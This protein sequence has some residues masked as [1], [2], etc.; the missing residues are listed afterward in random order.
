MTAA[1]AAV[2]CPA[3]ASVTRATAT[4]GDTIELP[5]PEA[6]KVQEDKLILR[7][8]GRPDRLKASVVPGRVRNDERV[9]V[10]LGGDGSVRSVSLEQR[11]D[12]Q[13]VGDYAIR[14]RGPAREATSLGPER[15]PLT[16]RGA[17]VWQGFTPGHR[18]LAARLRLDPAIESDHLPLRVRVTFTGPDGRA[19]TLADGGA[20][21]GP[22]TVHVTIS[23]ATSQPQQLPTGSDAPAQELAAPLDLA[24]QLARHPSAARLPTTD[25]RLPKQLAVA[26]GAVVDAS[27]GVPL[28]LTGSLRLVGTTGTVSGPATTATPDGADFAGTLGG[29]TTGTETAAVTF[30]AQVAGRG[31]LALD[32]RAVA[33]LNAL[34]LAPPR[35]FPTWQQ[36]AAAGPPARERKRALDLLVAVAATGARASSYS[37]YLGA[38]LEGSGTTSYAFG[39][40][41]ASA[42]PAAPA[43][44]HPRWGRLSLAGLGLLGLLGAGF[45][46]WR[47]A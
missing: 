17:V 18:A 1:G 7:V 14:E 10:G 19:T 22:G 27:Q 31:T 11:L 40:A 41:P 38:D 16:Q 45:G 34:E 39:F 46:V 36:W 28:R 3:S 8:G 43:V 21:P 5:T 20:L 2:V 26:D 24:L 42:R 9:V 6:A 13:G 37:P 29:S 47:R 35:S 4:F 32:L 15:P 23:N 33:S 25:D 12:V 30:D 44:V